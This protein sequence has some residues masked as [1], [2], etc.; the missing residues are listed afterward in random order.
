LSQQLEQRETH[1]QKDQ[2][3]PEISYHSPIP[4]A[5]TNLLGKYELADG[6]LKDAAGI[7]SPK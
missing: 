3:H 6:K 1:K 7:R 2:P 5:Y 4:W